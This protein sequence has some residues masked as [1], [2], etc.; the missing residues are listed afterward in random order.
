MIRESKSNE[1]IILL[2]VL[3]EAAAVSGRPGTFTELGAYDGI[4]GSQTW[5]L[6]KCFRWA[7]VLIE[8]SPKNFAALNLTHRN[9][10]THKE[11][12]AVCNFTGE[13]DVKSGGDTVAGVVSDFSK[14]FA[15]KWKRAHNNC[16]D[17]PCVSKVPCRPLPTIIAD[18]GFTSAV[19]FLSLDVEGGEERVLQSVR[20]E[21]DAFP[22]DGDAAARTQRCLGP[23]ATQRLSPL[24]RIIF[25]NIGLR[26]AAAV[27]MV[28]A[29]R[30]DRLK[31]ARVQSMLTHQWGLV[32][33]PLQFFRG[34]TNQL[35]TREG[36]RDVRPNFTT[37]EPLRAKAVSTKGET[38]LMRHLRKMH[39]SEWMNQTFRQNPQL[40]IERLLLGL[41]REMAV[42]LDHVESS[43]L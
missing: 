36:I 30:H 43:E 39:M 7:G 3:K 34:S 26:P 1:D 22:F 37:L 14:S 12:S 6:E 13:V 5:L 21:R 10:H 32:Q 24:P 11:H 28:E 35:Y 19:T 2:P 27:V 38:K 33:I 9:Q 29:D 18:A 16:G 15:M 25:L 41:P 20:P 4:L 31:N 40:P 17:M 23:R 8:A 42:L